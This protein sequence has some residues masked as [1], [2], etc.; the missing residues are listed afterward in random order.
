MNV[1]GTSD[2]GIGIAIRNAI[3]NPTAI[4]LPIRLRAI[5]CARVRRGGGV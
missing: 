4:A 2:N 5:S 1:Q 3:E